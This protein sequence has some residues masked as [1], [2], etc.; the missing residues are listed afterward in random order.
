MR[1]ACLASAA[2]VRDARWSCSLT[3]VTPRRTLHCASI[4]NSPHTHR[5]NPNGSLPRVAARQQLDLQRSGSL[6]ASMPR[7]ASAPTL[8]DLQ[9]ATPRCALLDSFP[10]SRKTSS[11]HHFRRCMSTASLDPL[12]DRS[13]LSFRSPSSTSNNVR[14]PTQRASTGAN[15]TST[16]THFLVRLPLIIFRRLVLLALY[17]IALVCAILA[18]SMALFL[19]WDR[20]AGDAL[21]CE[22]ECVYS[23]RSFSLSRTSSDN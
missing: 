18:A 19:L 11:L 23:S 6:R 14:A 10:A 5:V 20:A 4:S 7:S 13:P 22:G 21:P 1:H 9:S 2:C 12:G 15:A 17:S 16:L 8:Q 3:P